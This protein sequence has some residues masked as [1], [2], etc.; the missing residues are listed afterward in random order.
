MVDGDET[1]SATV[2]GLRSTSATSSTS[3]AGRAGAQ[4]E[5]APSVLIDR[6]R[7]ER[8]I[9]AGGMGVVYA[10]RDAHLGRAVAIKLVGPRIDPG[11]GQGRLARE[12]QAMANFSHPN[13]ATVYD[14]GSTGDRLFVVME[15]IDGGTWRTG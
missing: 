2:E 10:A 8:R 1:R 13:I 14:I 3:S 12:A 9:G 15:L 7:I 11:P 4:V 5:L 6:Y